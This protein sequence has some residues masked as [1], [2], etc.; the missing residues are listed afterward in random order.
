MYSDLSVK[1]RIERSR[2]QVMR[3]P[4]FCLLSGILMIGKVNVNNVKTACTDGVNTFYGE[5]FVSPL[6]EEETNFLVLHEEGHK[7]FSHLFMYKHLNKIDRTRTNKAMDYFINGW[8]I[9]T[10]PQGK[11]AKMPVGGLYNPDWSNKTIEE[12]FKLLEEEEEEGGGGSGGD[13]G[14]GTLDDHNWDG[15]GELTE[16]EVEVLSKDIEQALREGAIMVGKAKGNIDRRITDM[17]QPKIDWREVLRDFLN[18]IASGK[19][20]TSW[21]Q[22]NR[23]YVAYDLYLPSTISESMGELVIAVDTS[24]SIDDVKLQQVVGELVSLAGSVKPSLI[25]VL[26]WDT[27]IAKEQVIEGDMSRIEH[28]L[29]PAGGGGTDPSCVSK[30]I[31][32]KGYTPEAVIVFTD[33][34]FGKDVE[35]RITAPTLWIVDGNDSFVPPTN[36]KVIK[37]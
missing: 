11:F 28:N 21:R 19:D 29:E 35:W 26:W 25:R 34:C 14:D 17:L 15:A 23:R 1:T 6:I 13:E 4:D 5:A 8:I 12:I 37:Y 32:K 18:T 33:G 10:D 9:D 20:Q 16:E 24:G 30:H 31:I 36:G 2:S 27:H 22:F 3:H 7:A